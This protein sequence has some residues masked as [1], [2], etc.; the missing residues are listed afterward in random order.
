[1]VNGPKYFLVRCENP[2]N[3]DTADCVRDCIMDAIGFP[4]ELDT[5]P[6][7]LQVREVDAIHWK[8]NA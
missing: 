6:D 5:K 3:L 7:L 4:L 8:H 1:M 2:I